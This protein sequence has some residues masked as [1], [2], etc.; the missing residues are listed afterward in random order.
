MVAILET[1]AGHHPDLKTQFVHCTIDGSTHAFGPHVRDL[2]AQ[3]PNIE[4]TTFYSRPRDSDVAGRD[5]D[6][7]KRIDMDWLRANTPIDEADYFVCGPLPF[8]RTFV[9]G[10]VEAGVPVDRVHYEFFGPVEELLDEVPVAARGASTVLI[11]DRT[12]SAE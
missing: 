5:F 7:A 2:D 9:T 11:D 8:M 3:H 6:H 1:V 4:A 12:L 10:L